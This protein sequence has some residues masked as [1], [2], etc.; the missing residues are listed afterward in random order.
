MI[1]EI[2]SEE[3]NNDKTVLSQGRFSHARKPKGVYR[4]DEWKDRLKAEYAQTKEIFDRLHNRN[5]AN[6]VLRVTNEGMTRLDFKNM[7]LLERQERAMS[8]YL[9]CLELRAALNDIDL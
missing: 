7:E 1:L 3:L 5:I 4:M 6:E 2:G 8:E 9:Y